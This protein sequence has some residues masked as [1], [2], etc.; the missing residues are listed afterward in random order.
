RSAIR[1]LSHPGASIRDDSARL[2]SRSPSSPG[3]V[4]WP[5]V[6]LWR[7]ASATLKPPTPV[8]RRLLG[9]SESSFAAIACLMHGGDPLRIFAAVMPQ[10]VVD[11]PTAGLLT[12]LDMRLEETSRVAHLCLAGERAVG[13]PT[14]ADEADALKALATRGLNGDG[15]SSPGL[16]SGV[17]V[18]G[19]TVR[20]SV[21]AVK[22]LG[23]QT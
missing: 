23:V 14:D 22:G 3:L 16:G 17:C 19:D 10:V 21:Y 6:S 20:A 8:G 18:H 5:A 11:C 7:S 4:S 9:A 15:G 13:G 2:P 1:V 12:G